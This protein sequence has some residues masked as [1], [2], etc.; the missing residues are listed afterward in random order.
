MLN[1]LF[2]LK[3]SEGRKGRDL[4]VYK[5]LCLDNKFGGRELV[6]FILLMN[7]PLLGCVWTLDGRKLRKRKVRDLEG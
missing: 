5:F 2:G 1:T 6:S 7:K 3:E 4:K